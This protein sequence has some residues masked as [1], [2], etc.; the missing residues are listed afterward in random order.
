MSRNF[1]NALALALVLGVCSVGFMKAADKENA[2]TPE[3][4]QVVTKPT[5]VVAE[6]AALPQATEEIV[7]INDQIACRDL[8]DD[9]DFDFNLDDD[10]VDDDI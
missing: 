2:P 8:S 5:Q 1:A 4:A 9:S 3:T 7:T 10:D 6:K